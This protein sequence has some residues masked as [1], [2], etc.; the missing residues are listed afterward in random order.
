M[1]KY[2]WDNS[3]AEEETKGREV[4]VNMNEESEREIVKCQ[5]KLKPENLE[6]LRSFI[7]AEIHKFG[8]LLLSSSFLLVRSY[9]RLDRNFKLLIIF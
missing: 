3:W 8:S 1:K 4:K 7:V 2:L 5:I 9:K 6:H